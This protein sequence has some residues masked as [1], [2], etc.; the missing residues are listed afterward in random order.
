MKLTSKK[1]W[2][3]VRLPAGGTFFNGHLDDSD[4]TVEEA[5]KRIDRRNAL[6]KERGYEPSEYMITRVH[7]EKT[8]EDGVFYSESRTEECVEIYGGLKDEE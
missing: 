8:F 1:D 5:R 6:A 7:Y 3:A 2:Y 4:N